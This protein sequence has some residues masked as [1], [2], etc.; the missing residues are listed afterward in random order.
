MK[1]TSIV[2][3]IIAVLL[4]ILGLVTCMIAQ[5]MANANGEFLFSETREDGLVNTVDLTESEVSKI[6]LIVTDAEINIIGRSDK[7]CIEFVNFREN[8]YNLSAA[9]RVLSFSEIPDIMSMLKFWENGF[10]FKGMRYILNFAKDQEQPVDTKKVINLYL[11]SDKEIKIFEISGNNC[12]LNIEGMSS[13]TDYNITVENAEINTTGLKTT[14]NFNIN[15]K[16][17]DKP[18]QSVTLNMNTALLAHLN[19]NATELIMDANV[20]R[21]SA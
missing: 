3:L 4:I 21:C 5:N 2:S 11:T 13:A 15:S 17:S 20:F 8:Y 12:T 9:N 18:A 1:P 6:E 19:I 14:S 10:T 7:A 16:E